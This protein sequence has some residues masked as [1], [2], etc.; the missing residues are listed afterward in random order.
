MESRRLRNH[1]NRSSTDGASST[2]KPDMILAVP[3][4][5][6]FVGV[7]L[8][9]RKHARWAARRGRNIAC[10]GCMAWPDSP[11]ATR[12]HA[13]SPTVEQTELTTV[14]RIEELP[15][16]EW[17][18]AAH[19]D[20]SCCLCLELFERGE[21][22]TRLPACGHQYHQACI[23]RW[24]KSRRYQTRRCPLCNADAL[25]A[26]LLSLPSSPLSVVASFN[27]EQ[28]PVAAPSSASARRDQ[29]DAL[30]SAAAAAGPP[31]S[32]SPSIVAAAAA[33]PL[34]SMAEAWVSP[35]GT[36]HADRRTEAVAAA[37]AAAADAAVLPTPAMSVTH[38]S[39]TLAA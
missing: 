29:Y 35:G 23:T 4:F 22:V 34:R 14:E 15:S 20:V 5:V 30:P 31:A 27:S 25:A 1:Y 16:A 28:S 2:L 7:H 9:E 39:S 19:V 12:V 17:E 11:N 38:A 13:Q 24:L 10:F 8:L 33:A 32:E 6:V 36:L 3:M 21:I 18:S 26:D 37:V